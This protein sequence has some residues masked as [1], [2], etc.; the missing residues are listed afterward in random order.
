MGKENELLDAARTGNIAA[1]EKIL[2]QKST[3]KG[4]HLLSSLTRYDNRVIRVTCYTII[5]R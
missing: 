5:M 1:V 4:G 3:K 2:E